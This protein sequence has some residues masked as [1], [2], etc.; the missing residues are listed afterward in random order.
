MTL[1]KNEQTGLDID[2]IEYGMSHNDL[3]TQTELYNPE[4]P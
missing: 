3:G 2:T 4:D 1:T